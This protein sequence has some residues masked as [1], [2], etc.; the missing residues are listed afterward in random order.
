MPQTTLRPQDWAFTTRTALLDAWDRIISYLPNLI[1]AIITLVIGVLLGSLVRWLVQ[2]I[3]DTVRIQQAFDQMD[4][5]RSLRKAGISTD[6][7]NVIGE[8]F[9]WIIIIIFLRPAASFIGLQQVSTLLDSLLGFLPNVGSAIL[10]LFLGVLVSEFVGNVVRATAAGLGSRTANGLAVLTRNI[11]YIIVFLFA[12]AQLVTD[13]R[14]IYILLIGFVTA[15]AIALGLAF[16][17][18]GKNAAEDFIN[19]MKNEITSSK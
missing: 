6:L 19:R 18:G 10:I 7:G 16:G 13:P 17:L 11:I 12:F 1:Y 4:F 15:A 8:F 2:R 14:V 9:R 5:S 3:V